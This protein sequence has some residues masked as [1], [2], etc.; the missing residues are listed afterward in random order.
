MAYLGGR[1]EL[2][3]SSVCWAALA[4][5]GDSF[6][7]P[8]GFGTGPVAC[9]GPGLTFKALACVWLKVRKIYLYIIKSMYHKN[10]HD[11]K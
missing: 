3:I 5:T 7:F 2:R 6:C 8:G 1:M 11:S 10:I 9:D 4:S